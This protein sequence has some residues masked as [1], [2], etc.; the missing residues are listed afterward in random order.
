MT[1]VQIRAQHQTQLCTYNKPPLKRGKG[2]RHFLMRE[3]QKV[4]CTPL[5]TGVLFAVYV[6]V[7]SKWSKLNVCKHNNFK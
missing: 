4:S 6:D 7:A 5:L 1:S 3:T 2:G